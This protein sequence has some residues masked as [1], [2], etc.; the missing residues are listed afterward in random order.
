MIEQQRPS[1]MEFDE[2]SSLTVKS[3]FPIIFGF[4]GFGFRRFKIFHAKLKL[5]QDFAPV[6]RRKLCF[7]LV[8]AG[9]IV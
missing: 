1:Q 3:A 4:L 5:S 6:T 7:S 8:D 9:T 2:G